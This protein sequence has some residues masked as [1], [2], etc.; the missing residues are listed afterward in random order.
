MVIVFI[1][2]RCRLLYSQS[3]LTVMR[4][5][6]IGEKNTHAYENIDFLIALRIFLHAFENTLRFGNDPLLIR[7]SHRKK[8][9]HIYCHV[10]ILEMMILAILWKREMDNGQLFIILLYRYEWIFYSLSPTFKKENGTSKMEE[11]REH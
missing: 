5:I 3:I 9:E 2:S 11:G 7:N 8:T 6:F 1:H 10:S 4:K